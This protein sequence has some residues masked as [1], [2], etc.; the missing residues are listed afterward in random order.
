MPKIQDIKCH[1][2][3]NS[4]GEWT[5]ETEVILDDGATGSQTIPSG[6][7]KGEN[8]AVYVEVD[9]AIELVEGPI[10]DLLSKE[11][12]FDQPNIDGLMLKM[13]GTTNK[14]HLGGNS[15]LSV[16]LAVAKAC[17][18]SKDVELYVYLEELYG[19]KAVENKFPTP[20]FNILN[21]GKHADNNLSFQE[22]MVI[23]APNIEFDDALSIGVEVYQALEKKLKSD[24]YSVDV[25]DEGGFAPNGFTVEKALAYVKSAASDFEPGQKIFFGMDVAAG[26]FYKNK[27]YVIKEEDLKLA[28]EDLA[29][30]Y[31]ELIENF[32]LIYL[33]DPYFENDEEGWAIFFEEFGEKLM[34]IGDDLTVT[35]ARFLKPAIEKKLI[36]A[37]IV[38]PNQVGTLT[39]TFEF[40]GMAKDAGLS[41]I[42]SHR[43]GDTAEDTFI[44]D[45]SVAIGA[46][47]IKS[48]APARGERVAKYNRLLEIY[49]KE[50]DGSS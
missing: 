48:G 20:V 38:K 45:L 37:V 28:K 15:I 4:R 36:N 6:A 11:D 8:E 32:E 35:N 25:G 47:F 23:P 21:G 44:A 13:D 3:I 39:E 24:G 22:F 27:K 12:P 33:E 41:V 1:K 43:S 18:V 34:V 29:D 30:F 40:V 26:S 31:R 10:F 7:S 16:S 50:R 9:K 42:V 19:R 49:T 2:I 14:S 17:A 46:D 5:I